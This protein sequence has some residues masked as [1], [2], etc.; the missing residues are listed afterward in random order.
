MVASLVHVIRPDNFH[1]EVELE[2]KPVLLLCMPNGE[3]FHSQVKILERIA[4]QYGAFLKVGLIEEAYIRTFRNNFN[5]QGTP[6]L[7]M[8]EAGEEKTRMI[9]I[10]N[11]DTLDRFVAPFI[12][13]K[14]S[15]NT[16]S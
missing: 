7:L 8:M 4:A 14:L 3:M 9:G 5:I 1:V 10:V 11:M 13:K 2:K 15:V 12:K 16:L 6:T